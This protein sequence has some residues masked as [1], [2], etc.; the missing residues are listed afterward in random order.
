MRVSKGNH[1]GNRNHL[2]A[3]NVANHVSDQDMEIHGFP[4]G[5]DLY[6]K[7]WIPI[8]L[9]LPENNAK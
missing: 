8:S 5:H 6:G 7:C 4:M 1:K 2:L 3:G 9:L